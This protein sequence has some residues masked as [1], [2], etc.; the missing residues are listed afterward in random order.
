VNFVGISIC[1]L[2]NV[3]CIYFFILF[4]KRKINMVFLNNHVIYHIYRIF[5]INIKNG[6]IIYEYLLFSNFL[7]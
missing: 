6:N 7:L 2:V 3:M 4:L 1:T 5:F